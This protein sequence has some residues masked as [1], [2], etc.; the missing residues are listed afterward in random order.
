[1]IQKIRKIIE[2]LK[3]HSE[4]KGFQDEFSIRKKEFKEKELMNLLNE[5]KNENNNKIINNLINN[6]KNNNFEKVNDFLDELE[7]TIPEQPAQQPQ[8]EVVIDVTVKRLP[9]EIIDEITADLAEAKTCFNSEAYRSV[10]ILC[11]RALETALFRK[12][13]DV[14]GKDLLE[15]SPGTGLGKIIAK[16]KE[17]ELEFDPGLTEQIHLI[18]QVRVYSVHKKQ[19]PFQPTKEQAQAMMLYTIDVLNKLF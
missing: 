1:M 10:T 15:T 18:N 13:Y 4:K 3:K 11:G 8:K 19:R 7:K 5:I 12:Y 16:L 9:H 6:Y 17:A 14:T 2:Q